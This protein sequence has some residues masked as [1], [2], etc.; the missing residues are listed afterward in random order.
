MALVLKPR[1]RSGSVAHDNKKQDLIEWARYNR[2]LLA[3]HDLVGT[4]T[5]GRCCSASW[6]PGD[7]PPVGPLGGDLQ[8][9]P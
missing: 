2:R 1:K 6:P 3:M 9:G 8:V 4:G 7:L 5:T